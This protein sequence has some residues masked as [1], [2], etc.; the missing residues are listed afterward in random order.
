M[1]RKAAN[2][3]IT[4]FLDLNSRE[5]LDL[6][7]K[8]QRRS[9][10]TRKDRVFF[11]DT[12]FKGYPCPAVFL[13]KEVNPETG[14]PTYHVVDGKQRLETILLFAQNRI[15]LPK[16]EAGQSDS[17]LRGKKFKELTVDQKQR[18]W[19]Y[20][21]SVDMLDVLDQ[22]VVD[23]IFDR[24]NRNSRKL[25]RQELRHAKYDG[26]FINFAEN[27]S[28]ENEKWKALGIATSGRA[29]RMKDV[30]FISELM[31]ASIKHDVNGFSQDE[32]D[33]FC[34]L[35]D[36]PEEDRPEFLVE[37]FEDK[38]SKVLDFIYK[39]NVEN[40]C[41]VE[42]ARSFMHFYTLWCFVDQNIGSISD[43]EIA[44][45]YKGFMSKVLNSKVDE[46]ED[47]SDDF[48]DIYASNSVGA[49]TEYPQRRARLNALQGALL[50]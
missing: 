26:W 30:Q 27:Q 20:T 44:Q 1:D 19:N 16:D 24:L 32:I 22:A 45:K 50:A 33:E 8:Y 47:D 42:N 49:N 6:S 46:I 31:M 13:H 28:E 41:V 40:Q 10:W 17:E 4:W 48:H 2:Q 36:A 25:D 21:V 14:I 38:F 37:D 3:D 23:E 43:V 11:L 35:Y 7:P 18:F 5:Q 29:K 12:I 15:T 34:A 39:M 9:V